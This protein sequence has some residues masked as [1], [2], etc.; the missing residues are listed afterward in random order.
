MQYILYLCH[1]FFQGIISFQVFFLVNSFL[2]IYFFFKG[3]EPFRDWTNNTFILGPKEKGPSNEIQRLCQF[4]LTEK[5][6]SLS[7]SG[8][9]CVKLPWNPNLSFISKNNNK[10][11]INY[12]SFFLSCRRGHDDDGFGVWIDRRRKMPVGGVAT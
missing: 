4:L 7:V 1:G 9:E 8:K 11:D 3:A 5:K 12:L 6:T 10:N 2:V